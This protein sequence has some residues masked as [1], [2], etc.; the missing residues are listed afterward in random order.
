MDE[1][2]HDRFWYYVRD[3]FDE[4]R[5]LTMKEKQTYFDREFQEKT[6]FLVSECFDA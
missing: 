2:T 5:P 3:A 4:E 1:E 6:I